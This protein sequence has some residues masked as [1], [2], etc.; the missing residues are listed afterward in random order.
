MGKILYVCTACERAYPEG[1][2]FERDQVRVMPNGAW[3]CEGCYEEDA[4][5]FLPK[6][7]VDFPDEPPPW[8][9]FPEPPEYVAI[10]RALTPIAATKE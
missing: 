5:S 10:D 1:S 3:V 7:F 9:S 4:V 6:P 8:A 2:C